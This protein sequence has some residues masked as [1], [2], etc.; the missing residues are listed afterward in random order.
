MC[1]LVLFCLCFCFIIWFF[2]TETVL[3]KFS[4]CQVWCFWVFLSPLLVF[5]PTSSSFCFLFL[6]LFKRESSGSSRSHPH[7]HLCFCLFSCLCDRRNRVYLPFGPCVLAFWRFVGVPFCAPGFFW[8]LSGLLWGLFFGR[9][10]ARCFIASRA[11][12]VFPLFVLFCGF[13]PFLEARL[14]FLAE[15]GS[16]S[17][18]F[19]PKWAERDVRA[20]PSGEWSPGERFLRGGLVPSISGILTAYSSSHRVTGTPRAFLSGEGALYLPPQA[21]FHT[22]LCLFPAPGFF[23]SSRMECSTLLATMQTSERCSENTPELSECHSE[24]HSCESW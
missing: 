6:F 2:A 18:F 12:V 10:A 23:F 16:P 11:C 21:L 14:G 15:V 8:I 13:T 19:Q 5:S 9:E 17:R 1:F 7:T 20:R 4:W 22:H 24:R 3:K